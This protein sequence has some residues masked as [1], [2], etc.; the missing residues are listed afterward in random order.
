MLLIEK[1]PVL[2]CSFHFINQTHYH[3]DPIKAICQ[4][5]K[6]V[7]LED[8][9]LTN[10]FKKVASDIHILLKKTPCMPVLTEDEGKFVINTNIESLCPA[11]LLE[12]LSKK[13]VPPL[14][15]CA[16]KNTTSFSVRS[17]TLNGESVFRLGLQ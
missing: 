2:I 4:F 17:K 10:F 13:V 8:Q 9:I 3:S 7:P 14:H 12:N 6:F 15:H 11:C 16:A 5:L 1:R